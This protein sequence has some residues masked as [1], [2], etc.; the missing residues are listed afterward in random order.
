M[1]DKDQTVLPPAT[2]PTTVEDA[3][4]PPAPGTIPLLDGA[5][6]PGDQST[7]NS[8][9][10]KPITI[11]DKV[12]GE[13]ATNVLAHNMGVV[14]LPAPPTTGVPDKGT[15]GS[16]QGTGATG[17]SIEPTDSASQV[18]KSKVSTSSVRRDRARLQAE[19]EAL[20]AAQDQELARQADL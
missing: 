14:P 7:Q 8:L 17:E 2:A 3:S 19:A 15:A 4:V 20:Q 12:F 16:E 10:F 6:K 13:M 1:T 18:S 9:D 5:A 11:S